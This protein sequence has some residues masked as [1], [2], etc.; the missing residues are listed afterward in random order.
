M[1]FAGAGGALAASL[2]ASAASAGIAVG[3]TASGIAYAASGPAAVIVTG[4]LIAFVAVALAVATRRLRP[5]ADQNL[6]QTC[7]QS[8]RAMATSLASPRAEP[9][10]AC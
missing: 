2:P 9:V 7:D 3:S 8:G 6:D 10:L 1:S 4:A 5:P